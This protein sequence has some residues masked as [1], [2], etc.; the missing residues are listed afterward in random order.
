MM[1]DIYN[2]IYTKLRTDLVDIT[3]LNAYTNESSN[4]PCVSFEE[5]NNTS[6]EETVD[7][8]GE[9]HADLSFEINICTNSP[10][11]RTDGRKIMQYVDDILGGHYGLVRDISR[12][13]P[14]PVDKTIHRILMRYSGTVSNNKT[15][16]RG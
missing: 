10:K 5:M 16:Y 9:T 6:N 11:A 13:V 1:V 12:P 2:E 15:I 8:S 14:N 3:V 4:F 7:N